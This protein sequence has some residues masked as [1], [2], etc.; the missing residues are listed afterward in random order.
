MILDKIIRKKKQVVEAE[1]MKMPLYRM[2]SG[3]EAERQC[4][5]FKQAI[6]SKLGLSMIAEVKRASPSKG[7]IREDFNPLEIAR[8]Y[9]Q[10]KAE[11]ISVLTEEHFFQGSSRYLSEIR[12][13][14]DI[15]LLRKDFI[16]DPYQI[17]QSKALGADVILLVAAALCTKELVLFQKIAAEIG[18]QCLVEVHNQEELDIAV[19]AQAEIIGINNRSLKTFD[20]DIETTA[21]LINKIPKGKTIISE[22]GIH[23]RAD[24]KYLEKLGVDGVLIGESLMRASSIRDKMRELRGDRD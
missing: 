7:I 1:K 14:A 13:F 17:Y 22:S 2:F 21:H 20:T 8:S 12:R 9:Q 5:D 23:T 19:E 16:I 24:M 18:L 15:P 11:A 6:K 3:L 10:N 4:L